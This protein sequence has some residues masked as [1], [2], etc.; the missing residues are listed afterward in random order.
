MHDGYDGFLKNWL[1]CIPGFSLA[2][3]SSSSM[4]LFTS[5]VLWSCFIFIT[6][7][8]FSLVCFPWGSLQYISELWL[9][10]WLLY[11]LSLVGCKGCHCSRIFVFITTFSH[12]LKI[13]AF[14]TSHSLKI[15]VFITSPS[16]LLLTSFLSF[17]LL[18]PLLGRHKG[19]AMSYILE[20]SSKGVGKTNLHH[21][22]LRPIFT[23]FSV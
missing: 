6:P 1:F 21:F 20:T 17:L 3:G 12:F 13:F 18:P 22:L 19:R 14:L 7:L 10:L 5:L 15:F 23:S 4:L 8:T 16:H 11:S 9:C 2:W